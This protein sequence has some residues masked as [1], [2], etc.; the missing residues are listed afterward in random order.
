MLDFLRFVKSYPKKGVMQIRPD[1]DL[2]TCSD[3]MIRGGHF[4]AIWV[5]E[6]GKWSTNE[7]DAIA[8]ID[9]E[10]KA[11][12]EE[13]TEKDED[14]EMIVKVSYLRR[15]S[16]GAIDGWIKFCER[17]MPDNYHPLDETLIFSNMEPKKEDYSSKC[18]PYPLE[19]GDH[20]SWDR[21]IGTLYSEPERHKLEWAI[22]SIVNGD[23][24]ELQKFIVLYG[25]AGT[26]K[27]TVLNIISSLFE[28]YCGTFDAKA[29]G[30][31][32][33][34][35]AFE[36]FKNNPL[37][38]IQHDGD[39][40]RI[41]DNTRL[42]SL[43]SHE[44]VS[45]NEK[46]RSI[47]ERQ[48]HSFLFMGTNK[49]V[50]ITDAK[51][52]L[53]RRLIDVSPSGKKINII[54][55][56][57]L[58]RQIDFELGAIAW[59]CKEVYEADPHAYDDYVPLSMMGASNDFYNFISDSY[60]VFRKDDGTSLKAAWEMYKEY[61]EDA[62]V[63]YPMPR[64]AFQEE[65]KNY[66]KEY[67]ERA[68]IP[69]TGTRVR[70]YYSGFDIDKF[71]NPEKIPVEEI[72][73]T[74]WLEFGANPSMFD[75]I[76]QNYPAQ[77]ANKNGTPNKKWANVTTVLKDLDST[78]L[79]Y[80]KV[81]YEHIVIDF[82]LTDA[83]G[84]KSLE[85]NLK[86]ASKWPPTYAELSKSGKGIH[87]HYIYTGGDP[88]KLSRV[89]APNVEI[90]VF[91]G[92]SS[93][94]RQ[95]TQC[96]ELQIAN[97]SSGLPLKGDSP[98]TTMADI[99]NEQALIR[100]VYKGIH[101]EYSPYT[102]PSIDFIK[103]DMDAAYRAGFSYDIWN[104]RPLVLELAASSTHNAD[105][106]IKQVGKMKFRSK[107]MEKQILGELKKT[108]QEIA[109]N[110]SIG[111]R[112]DYVFY[113]CE[114]F[115]T[116]NFVNWKLMGPANPMIQWIMPTPQQIEE[117][118]EYKLIGFNNRRY[119]NHIIYSILIGY[120][121][122]AVYNLSQ[123]IIVKRDK[124]AFFGQAYN[125]SYT[126]IYDYCAKK[127]SLKKWEVELGIHHQELG[128]PWDEPLPKEKWPLVSEYCDNDVL[129]TEAVF[130][131]TQADFQARLILSDLTG[132]TPNDTTNSQSTRLIFGTNR[133]P[134]N[135]FNYR[136]L[137][138]P[139][140]KIDK[141]AH[142][143]FRKRVKDKEYFL[144]DDQGRPNFKGY[145]YN[146]GVSLYRDE[147]VGEG[148]YVYA[149][150]GIYTNVALLDVASMHPTSLIC[151]NLFGDHYTKRFAELKEARLAIK[152]EDWDK[153]ETLMDGKLKPYV[154]KCKSGDIKH[155]DLAYA[156][157]IVINSVYGLT[158][159]KFD[160]PFRDPRNVDNIVAKRGA[161]F[162]VN[163]KHEV[164]K[165]GFTVA[166]IKTDSIKIP[167][168]TPE[169]IQF[170]MDYGKAYGYDFEHEATYEKMCLV[171]DAVY[172]AKYANTG[173]WTATGTQFQVPYVFKTLFSREPIKFSDLCETKS[174]T[175]ALY[176]DFNEGLPDVSEY[177]K[178]RKAAV[179][180]LNKARKNYSDYCNN[181]Q[182]LERGLK[183]LRDADKTIDLEEDIALQRKQI[184]EFDK[185][186]RDAK[187]AMDSLP[188]KIAELDKKIAPGHDY[189]FIGR[190]GLFSPVIE[191]G[192]LLCREQKGEYYAATGSKGYRWAESET[193]NDD[194]S[195]IDMRYYKHLVDEAADAVSQYGDLEWFRS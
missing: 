28:G 56:R 157:K 193:L 86:E 54:E 188:I 65:L 180:K 40:S 64:R 139:D 111:F 102:K 183:K 136:N 44:Y 140:V 62:R 127:Q 13:C 87:L 169:I 50:K 123:R 150:P 74:T 93:L 29:L 97:I 5:E 110:T 8:L 154:E 104:L 60:Y 47:Y 181:V 148:G 59:H 186:A 78:K 153:A 161:L 39:L 103:K 144:F 57:Q 23:S 166:H 18:L 146:K 37:V 83:T 190:V 124:N 107:D 24:K 172:I 69:E 152:H 162:M 101:K 45:V 90:K 147:E 58:L 112:N 178:E 151:E 174:V 20:S 80:I 179:S 73:K 42:N 158:S 189:K 142:A 79:H 159:A 36:A 77:Y 10:L 164:Q 133:H 43:V 128:I 41:E 118:L 27:S 121:P 129:A 145:N 187:V 105:Y 48:F 84:E 32:T 11:Y 31:S 143:E 134:Q 38:A 71:E 114:V 75:A 26:G 33:N 177:E 9:K 141:S 15:S 135:D 96:N 17:Q 122:D 92:D 7:F 49:P 184:E 21:L 130:N 4:Y 76:A 192:G 165:Q 82:D 30:S 113:D 175:S 155:S 34:Q 194:M 53:L 72:E 52:G 106:C 156:L 99:K 108:Q 168:A 109:E 95:L 67:Q 163:L 46:N 63:T 81:P 1:Y 170:V 137:G 12:A 173:K 19:K 182:S 126:D 131:A 3:L 89:Y 117:L 14:N 6:L 171:N 160:N 185:L 68:Y 70:S 51:S 55:Y 16:S 119:D 35:F 22:G 2:L 88:E 66:F 195:K 91:T 120:K 25:S 98:M 85:R 176:L 191:D 138:D 116:V 125:L 100:R 132:L 167:N 149:E 115:P 61:C 94:R